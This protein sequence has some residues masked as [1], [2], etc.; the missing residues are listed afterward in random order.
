MSVDSWPGDSLEL[1]V[2]LQFV[3]V[4][5][6]VVDVEVQGA[7]DAGELAASR[8]RHDLVAQRLRAGVHRPELLQL[9]AALPLAEVA[10]PHIVYIPF[11]AV[12][13]APAGSAALGS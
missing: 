13:V 12:K 7:D 2:V 5:A 4:R 11:I 10:L 6:I 3:V 8:S 1:Q 9:E